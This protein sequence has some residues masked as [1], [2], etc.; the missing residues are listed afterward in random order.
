MPRAS[1]V[2]ASVGDEAAAPSA[3][4]RRAPARRA[5]RY[6]RDNPLIVVGIA[7]MVVWIVAALLTPLI[8]PYDPLGQN[9]MHRLE[10]PE[11][12]HLFGT[13]DLGRDVFSRV[14]YGARVS[15][16]LGAI[17]VLIGGS[18]GTLVGAV[19]GYAG[20]W[21]DET[22]MRFTDLIF[23]FPTII[24]AMAVAAALGP[25]LD[26]SIL[27]I[28]VVWWPSYAR[29]ARAM[30]LSVGRE[31]YVTA[32]HAAGLGT[33]RIM[34]SHILRNAIGPLVVL[35]TLDVGNAILTFSGLSFLGLGATPPTAEWGSM[36]STGA[37]EMDQWW[38]GLFP[39]LAIWTVVLAFNLLGDGLRD[40]L[41]PQGHQT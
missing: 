34:L 40:A 1:G 22:L 2:G 30:V 11:A 12:G 33:I 5:G 10:P 36:V 31:E 6:V 28:V 8:A 32:A 17:L 29:L 14:L 4:D 37:Q 19:A 18:F 9:I 3:R 39:G 26:H 24:L 20:G 38:L 25:S 16:P 23:A 15:L 41:D 13:D 27:A 21:L 35:A 7:V